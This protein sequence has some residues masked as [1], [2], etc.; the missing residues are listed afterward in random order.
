M[1]ISLEK[2][3]GY[4]IHGYEPGAVSV[5]GPVADDRPQREP[6]ITVYRRSI[7]ITPGELIPDWAP[8]ALGDLQPAHVEQLARFGAQVVLLGS[9]TSMGFPKAESLRPL[10]EAGLGYEVMDTGAACRTYNILAAEG[11]LVAAGLIID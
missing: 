7:I 1:K 6:E 5:R 10:I 8:Q 3:A 9:G 11:R 2:F 4:S